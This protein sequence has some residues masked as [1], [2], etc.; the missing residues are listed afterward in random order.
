M[1]TQTV[2][3]PASTGRTLTAKL[4]AIGSD[5]QV[6]SQSATEATNRKGVYSVAFT[7][8]PAAD[9]HLV[10]VDGSSVP[11]YVG[12]VT[13]T[14][15]TATFQA[16][17]NQGSNLTLWRGTAPA[18]LADT[19]KVPASIQHDAL[20]LATAANL[21]T[22]AGYLDTEIAAILADT[23]ELQADWA[24]GGR[25]D[26]ILDAILVDTAVIGAA[27]AGLTSV[28]WNA[29]WDEQVQ[30]EVQDAIEANNLDH[31]VKVAVDTDFATTVHLDSVLGQMADNGTSA[32]FDRTTD[33]LEALANAGG[34]GLTEQ[35]IADIASAV[36]V[37]LDGYE[38]AIVSPVLADGTATIIQGDTYSAAANQTLNWTSSDWPSVTGATVTFT[39]IIDGEA[40]L[41]KS[42][43]VVS[44]T[45]VRLVLTAAEAAAITSV[46]VGRYKIVAELAASAGT[47]TL[48]NGKLIVTDQYGRARVDA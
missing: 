2:E 39:G 28:P 8:A 42:M 1:A 21:A 37:G 34:A 15:T 18:A 29:D 14:L 31:L 46:G 13:L 25:L 22:V 19:D 10:V 27:G 16:R 6:D 3:F 41:T 7:D 43:T 30:S 38:I 12:F 33:S 5:T 4:F 40:V 35:N 20:G 17:D 23:N 11:A 44:A 36:V 47:R 9:Y 32:S 24:D 48:A 45:Q 26:V